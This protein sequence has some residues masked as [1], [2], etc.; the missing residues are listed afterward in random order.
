MSSAENQT[1]QA[2]TKWVIPT[3][4]T[5]I[6]GFM[7]ILDASIVNVAIP[8]MMN[9][10]QTSLS[11]IQWVSTIYM[12]TLGV[13]VPTSGWLGDKLGLKRLY[14]YSLAVFTVGSALCAMAASENF[15]IIARI[16]QAIGGGMIMP[17]MMTMIYSIVPKN[18]FGQ[19][20]ALIG[21]TMMVAPAVGP[22]L[23]GY[24]VEYVNW[25][26]IFTINLPVGVMAVVLS[27]L[28]L[29]EISSHREAGKFD[30][31]GFITSS[32]GLFC[33]L[34]ALTQ[35]S[36][37]GWTSMSIVLLLWISIG[38]LG[39][40][41]YHELTTSN[42]LLDLRIFKIPT[43][44]IG[45][46]MA[47]IMNIVMFSALFYIPFF[48]QSIRGMG[49]LEVGVL[50]LPPAVVSAIMMPISGLLF[51][52]TGARIPVVLGSIM[53]TITVFLFSHI[54]IN[55]PLRTI[56]L[57]NCLR[58]AGMSLSM[59]PLQSAFMTVLPPHLMSRGSAINNIISRVASSFGLAV[60]TLFVTNRIALHS[61]YISWNISA[62]ALSDLTARG[63][64]G[65]QTVFSLLGK[66]IYQISFVKAVNEMFL[67]STGLS[68][69]SILPGFVFKKS[70]SLT[71][72]GNT[73]S[74]LE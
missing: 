11:R 34:L 52:K 22:T 64:A 15:L 13:V 53:T 61:S 45:N 27:F 8:T 50:M 4:V 18:K 5:V 36:D 2:T 3:L 54:D 56:V 48:L 31:L 29:P 1:E 33:L 25:R 68:L 39:I 72:P 12:L 49:A 74:S 28:L 17:T 47:A 6:G 7:S 38:F 55:T 26:W 51:D 60:L 44:T 70:E 67:L 58:Q 21:I 43:F 35:G 69:I 20:T 73:G 14:T 9:N 16:I 41:V 66:S 19:S 23:G 62:Q 59:M 24:L 40:F 63:I 57:W 30:I 65:P 10:F 42:P 32:T 71:G 46:A 37:W